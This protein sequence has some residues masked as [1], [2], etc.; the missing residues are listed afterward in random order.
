MRA[1]CDRGIWR[2]VRGSGLTGAATSSFR[3]GAGDKVARTR[4]FRAGRSAEGTGS[5][6]DGSTGCRFGVKSAAAARRALVIRSRSSPRAGWCC[7]RWLSKSC[8]DCL[9]A[10]DIELEFVSFDK[11]LPQTLGLPYQCKHQ[12]KPIRWFMESRLSSEA[13]RS[14]GRAVSALK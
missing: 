9:A 6:T 10:R 2:V 5:E 4:G 14:L 11:S 7:S 1:W 12:Q 13:K 8:P 3:T